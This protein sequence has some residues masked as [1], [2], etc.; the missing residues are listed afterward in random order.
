MEPQLAFD[1]DRQF[2][3]AGFDVGDDVGRQDH[4]PLARELCKQVPEALAF[5]RIQADGRLV[6]DQQL[7]II[8]QGLGD[9]DALAHAARK[10]AEPAIGDIGKADHV[11][12]FLDA[13]RHRPRG[14]ALHRR[15][16][17]E[18]LPRRQGFIDAE[19][20]RQVAQ[21]R[22]QRIRLAGD[23]LTTP[24]HASSGGARQGGQHAHQARL[25]GAIRA[26]QADDAGA[27][28][29]SHVLDRLMAAAIPVTD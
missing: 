7:R 14:Q 10:P 21:F 17:G 27:E 3:G 22:T 11:Q 2:A 5:L 8:E 6:D 16:K 1:E 26:Q 15:E 19:V 13:C 25:A 28:R 4:Q 23:V 18:E 20:L 12:A 29:Q 24:E 9:A